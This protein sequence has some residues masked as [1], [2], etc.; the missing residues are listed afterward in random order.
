LAYDYI[1]T[2]GVIVPD[3]DTTLAEVQ[4]E[5]R[6]VFGDDIDLNPSSPQGLIISM[7]VL[8]RQGVARNNAEIANQINPNYSSGIFLDALAALSGL[9]RTPATH[10]TVTATVTGDSGAIIYAGA[11]AETAAGDRFECTTATTIPLSGTIDAPFRSVDTGAIPCATGALT[12]IVDGILGWA[13]ITNSQ[14]GILGSTTQL[15]NSF[16]MLRRNTLA[17]QGISTNEAIISAINAVTGVQS[18]AYRENT[19][20]ITTVIDGISMVA[21]S[22]Y[23]CVNG[24]TDSDIGAAL[25]QNKTAG[26]GYNGT[27][28]VAVV[29]T[30]SGQSYDVK[31][32]RPTTI[33]VL[34]R[35][36]VRLSGATG[37]PT[38]TIKSKVVSYANGEIEGEQGF[39]V[40]GAV[41]PFE[42]SA[43]AQGIVGVYVLNSEIAL[44]SDGIFQTTEIPI[45][46]DEIATITLSSVQVVIV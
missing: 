18:L 8:E 32:Q 37:D 11:L 3:T 31:F 5:W 26:A 28:T 17:L 46:I 27:T 22:I 4:A 44:A 39:V 38:D 25:L 40:G 41:S 10:T 15:D 21:H 20:A 12:I 24:G 7:Q 42:L 9:S 1:T 16:W 2:T 45:S 36:T 14:A 34:S 13:S 19:A 43:A 6:A 30:V 33:P 35:I 29:D 23:V